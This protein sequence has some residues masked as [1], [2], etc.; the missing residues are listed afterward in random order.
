MKLITAVIRPFQIDVVKEALED[1]G[2]VGMTVEEVRGHGRQGG[3]T[4]TYRGSEYKVDFVPKARID[5]VVEDEK[6]EEAIDAVVGAART[7]QIGDGKVWVSDV[8]RVVRVRTGE[9]DTDAL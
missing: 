6:V 9:R 2:V 1:L 4:E 5:V 3:H 8:V 7:G